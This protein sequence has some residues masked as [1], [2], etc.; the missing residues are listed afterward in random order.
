[1]IDAA[2]FLCLPRDFK[3]LCKIYPPTVTDVVGN[4]NYS[5]YLQIL[6]YSQEE[7]EDLF[8]DKANKTG[9]SLPDKF[10]TPMELMLAN[11]Y[12]SPEVAE[13]TKEAFQ[14]FIHQD[15]HFI[16]EQKLILIGGLK[17]L[18]NITKIEELQN[19]CLGEEDFFAFQNMIR[20]S[21]GNKAI[22]KPD[23]TEDPRVKRIKA[24]ARYRDKIK[25]KQ[26]RGLTLTA[27]IASICCMGIG[28][29]PLNIG[30]MSYAALHL[31]T[32]IYQEKEKYDIDIRS[33]LAGADK[34][35][36]KPIYWIRNFEED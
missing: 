24:K 26:G 5:S 23:P 32:R 12:N 36:V 3:N 19:Y 34:K 21:I 17:V 7:I 4:R 14:F 9:M 20:M 1:M 13:L 29:T 33:L 35:K 16:F 22:E 25:A 8:V 30:E 2:W 15:V 11:A 28:L 31:L 27:S 10:P 6:T 18:E